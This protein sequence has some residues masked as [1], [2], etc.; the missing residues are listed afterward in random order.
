MFVNPIKF[1]IKL[2]NR[3]TLLSPSETS[4]F[5]VPCCTPLS[6]SF[7]RG[8]LLPVLEIKTNW[9]LVLGAENPSSFLNS[10]RTPEFV[11]I[12]YHFCLFVWDRAFS[13]RLPGSSVL[14]MA[15]SCQLVTGSSPWPKVNFINTV[16]ECHSEIK[17]P[18]TRRIPSWPGAH[19]VGQ[20][21]VTLPVRC[22]PLPP[23]C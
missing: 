17:Y 14:S 16:S 22:F 18:K 15:N 7:L 5:L 23:K 12:F 21:R 11:L 3:R 1:I 2:A 9:V 19:W 8:V 10:L 13:I 20:V 6:T 4:C